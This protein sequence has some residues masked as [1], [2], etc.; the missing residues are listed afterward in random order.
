M[1]DFST[2]IGE[3]KGHTEGHDP[4]GKVVTFA[5]VVHA[6]F[7]YELGRLND[8]LVPLRDRLMQVIDAELADTQRD[9]RP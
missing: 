7:I 3:L 9:H 4:A 8:L 1:K 2:Y 5:D 6:R